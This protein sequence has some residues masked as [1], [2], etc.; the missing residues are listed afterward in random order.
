MKSLQGIFPSS[1]KKR[2]LVLSSL[3]LFLP[4]VNT[5]TERFRICQ[6]IPIYTIVSVK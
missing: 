3:C 4:P 2:A 1:V 5:S 6:K